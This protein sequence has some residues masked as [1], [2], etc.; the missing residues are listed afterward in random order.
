LQDGGIGTDG[1]NFIK[2]SSEQVLVGVLIRCCYYLRSDLGRCCQMGARIVAAESHAKDPCFLRSERSPT[3]T[4]FCERV[5][6]KMLNQYGTA[7]MEQLELLL[8]VLQLKPGSRVLDAGCGT[9]VTTQYLSEMTGAKFVG[10][11]VSETAI[12]R[13]LE[14]AQASPDRLDFKVGTMDALDF[15]PASF[16]AVIAV[17][18]LYF[19]K[20]LAGAISQFKT[21]LRSGGRMALFYTHIADAPGGGVG[22]ANTKLAGALR[23]CGISFETHDL[24]E[25]DRRFWQRSKEAAEELR[26]DFEAEENGDLAHLSET[27]AVLDFVRQGRH[28][29]YL[30]CVQVP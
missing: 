6:G 26:V 30:Y 2:C 12:R 9:G 20:D 23:N 13:A 18:S 28:A 29:R 15:P 17:E 19:P 3:F 4:R 8:K 10:I 7:D 11:D 22:P 21:V 14:L 5:Y 1:L 27:N 25:S 24:S 16:D